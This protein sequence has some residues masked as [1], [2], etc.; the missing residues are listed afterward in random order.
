[1]K[2]SRTIELAFGVITLLT[3]IVAV[4][5]SFGP[6]YE[7]GSILAQTV[8]AVVFFIAPGLLTTLGAYFHAIKGTQRGFVLLWIGGGFL[9]LML[10]VYLFG[11]VFYYGLWVG[12]STLSPSVAALITLVV[13]LF[14][15][16]SK[17]REEKTD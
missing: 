4:T 9:S 1:M 14:I 12:L 5:V 8:G 3:A 7:S 17:Q 11:R 10:I 16:S 6:P 2:T 15:R 13:S